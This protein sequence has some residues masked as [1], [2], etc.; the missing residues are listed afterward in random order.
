MPKS[1]Q[2]RQ[3][4]V[5]DFLTPERFRKFVAVELRVTPRFRNRANVDELFDPVSCEEVQEV[6]DGMSG[7]ADGKNGPQISNL[8]LLLLLLRVD[9]VFQRRFGL[10]LGCGPFSSRA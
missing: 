10:R 3:V 9:V 2:A 6:G 7:V 5:F 8:L 1:A 4:G